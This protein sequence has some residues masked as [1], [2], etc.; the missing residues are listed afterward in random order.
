MEGPRLKRSITL[1][2]MGDW[3]QA[4]LHR[5]CGWLAQELGSRSGRHSRFAIWN[6]RGGADAVRAVGRGQVDISLTTPA[7]FAIAALDGRPPYAGEAYPH[8]RALGTIAQRDRLVLAVS[9]KHKLHSFADFRSRRLPLRISTGPDD[10]TNNVGLA[11]HRVM[12]LENIEL[13]RWG[14]RYAEAER[15]SDCLDMVKHGE[16]DGVFHEAIMTNWWQDLANSVDLTYVPIERPV[17]EQLDKELQWPSAALPAGYLR[18]LAAELET[19]DF[20]DFLI[21]TR[22]DLPDDVAELI[23]WCIVETR[24]ALEEHYRHIPPERSPVTYP[25]VP[26]LMAKTA[27]PLHPG[28]ARYYASKGYLSRGR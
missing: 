7:A 2:F 24:G 21:V 22:A 28:A 8:L 4:N 9:A 6:G 12:E 17:L 27:I 18:G 20:S 15:P 5:V 1:H 10:G 3:G 23:A 26:S 25:L 14:G 19:L 16:A 13:E 11:V